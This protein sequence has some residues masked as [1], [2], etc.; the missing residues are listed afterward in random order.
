RK[1]KHLQHLVWYRDAT[2]ASA[3][4]FWHFPTFASM[5]CSWCSVMT[6]ASRSCGAK[7]CRAESTK[8]TSSSASSGEASS[9]GKLSAR[10]GIHLVVTV[11]S[12]RVVF[13]VVLVWKYRLTDGAIF[14]L[15][16]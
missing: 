16:G 4:E 13:C 7:E 15:D 14:V 9:E 10:M 8:T 6:R 2:S 3:G 1:Y 11:V 12:E 5:G